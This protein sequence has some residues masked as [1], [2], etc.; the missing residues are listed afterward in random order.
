MEALSKGKVIEA[1]L[2][3]VGASG[4]GDEAGLG[5]REGEHPVL[6]VRLS[7]RVGWAVGRYDACLGRWG[8]SMDPEPYL[9]MIRYVKEVYGYEKDAPK[10]VAVADE[11][12]VQAPMRGVLPQALE[13]IVPQWEEALATE[14]EAVGESRKAAPCAPGKKRGRPR[15][16]REEA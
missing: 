4:L 12:A 10:A 11:A 7:G 5:A 6:V 8:V 14:D 2:R 1:V 3:R 13:T 15:K 16:K 9:G